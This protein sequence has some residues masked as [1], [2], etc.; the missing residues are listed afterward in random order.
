M[1][2]PDPTTDTGQQEHSETSGSHD[3]ETNSIK[4]T[5]VHDPFVHGEPFVEKKSTFQVVF[6]ICK[7]RLIDYIAHYITALC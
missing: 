5:D 2:W 6:S 7:A 3:A 4:D 1:L